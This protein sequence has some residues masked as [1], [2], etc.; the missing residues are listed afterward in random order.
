MCDT[1]SGVELPIQGSI[2]ANASDKS[3]I[4]NTG[5]I[6]Q[7]SS[8]EQKGQIA[9]N[10][11]LAGLSSY[12]RD[13]WF[14][15]DESNVLTIIS[16]DQFETSFDHAQSIPTEELEATLLYAGN[17]TFDDLRVYT[18]QEIQQLFVDF[19]MS[20]F[21]RD[22]PN[23]RKAFGI[24]EDLM[25][26]M[27]PRRTGEPAVSHIYRNVLRVIEFIKGFNRIYSERNEVP[28]F[29]PEIAEFYICAAAMHDFL[30]D[31]SSIPG[32][33][34]HRGGCKEFRKSEFE[35]WDQGVHFYRSIADNP[36]SQTEDI[37]AEI[38]LDFGEYENDMFVSTLIAL[39]SDNVDAGQLMDH[40]EGTVDALQGKYDQKIMNNHLYSLAAY[41]IK[42]CDRLD[43]NATY[44]FKRD[45]LGN[46]IPT[47]PHRVYKKAMENMILF[48]DVLDVLKHIAG[49]DDLNSEELARL[50]PFYLKYDPT[51]WA[52]LI[53]SGVSLN[54]MYK[55]NEGGKGI[56]V[57]L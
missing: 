48:R 32:V 35:Q 17:E 16:E 43:N 18:Y 12:D 26:T 7:D 4:T 19:G 50:K 2:K 52:K 44:L 34:Y 49:H 24:V 27:P 38:T 42:C 40:L 21:E 39:K 56:P 23:I 13:R 47:K 9:F 22:F 36:D 46:I 6:V 8:T 3:T 29:T 11:G 1:D 51:R 25:V 31:Y 10:H 37:I 54:T 53:L 28:I 14:L 45:N 15:D 5:T 20:E 41:V 30:E 57:I 55:P 33:G